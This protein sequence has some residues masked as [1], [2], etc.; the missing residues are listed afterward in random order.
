MAVSMHEGQ[1]QVSVETVRR[2]V[3]Q[4]FPAWSGLAIT[5][6]D[7]SG[8]VNALFR[9]GDLLAARFPL[10]PSDEAANLLWL[11]TEARAAAEL[12]GQTRFAT[13][14]PVAI[15]SPGR[16]YPLHWSVQTWIAGTVALEDDPAESV[17][18]ASDVADFILGVR[19]LDIRGR[20]F[21]GDGR[22]GDLRSH[23]EWLATCFSASEHLVDVPPLRAVWSELRTLP[24]CAADT[25]THGDLMPG[26]VLVAA[27]RLQGV[28]DVGG[29]GPADPAL[30]LV[31]AW[32]LLESGPRKVLR[33]T[34]GCDDV[35]WARGQAWALQQAM[36]LV[37]YYETSNPVM[38]RIG[39]R[40]LWRILSAPA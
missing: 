16:G 11:E 14:A 40:T 24:R 30:D 37:W 3:G 15:G 1:L 22:G 25:M 28:L 5:P 20:T 35:E 29:L 39:R 2:L 12:L 8:T 33:Q 36:G 13:P 34:L 31:S 19:G 7:S 26:N 27:G 9:I 10:Q 6:V 23:D 4:Q 21:S 38:S 17:P 18:F 32:H